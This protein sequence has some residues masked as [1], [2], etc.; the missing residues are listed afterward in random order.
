MAGA[1]EYGNELSGSIKCGESYVAGDGLVSQ[2]GLL[3]VV[4]KYEMGGQ[5]STHGS[6]GDIGCGDVDYL[7]VGHKSA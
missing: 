5:C 2:E 1:C 6:D 7:C 4:S 3:H